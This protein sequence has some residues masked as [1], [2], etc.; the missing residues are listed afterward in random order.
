MHFQEWICWYDSL[1]WERINF[2]I[3]MFEQNSPK[4]R[5]VQGLLFLGNE[6]WQAPSLPTKWQGVI[7]RFGMVYLLFSPAW[8]RY[9][10][11]R[12]LDNVPVCQRGSLHMEAPQVTSTPECPSK[13]RDTQC[14]FLTGFV[15]LLVPSLRLLFQDSLICKCRLPWAS[16][17]QRMQNLCHCRLLDE[18][19]F[20]IPCTALA[21]R[22]ASCLKMLRD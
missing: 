9:G 5:S 4:R 19:G 10:F 8:F 12:T 7:K 15:C 16:G 6:A 18:L 11:Q 3:L 13:L 21:G 20:Q 1:V 2:W 14:R 22:R 17:W